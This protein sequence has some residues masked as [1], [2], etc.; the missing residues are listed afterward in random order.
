MKLLRT[1]I[2][3]AL[4]AAPAVARSQ[5]Q[6]VPAQSIPATLAAALYSSSA[7]AS[8]RF[9]VNELPPGYPGSLVPPGHVTILGGT[10]AY[11]EIIALFSDSTQRLAATFEELLPNAGWKTPA[12]RGSGGF[13]SAGAGP[14]NFYCKGDSSLNFVPLTGD[15]RHALRVSLRPTGGGYWCA[16]HQASSGG[17]ATLTLP[18][19][20]APPHATLRSSGG[21]SGSRDVSSYGELTG[22]SL[23]TSAVLEH[24]S[25]QL[26]AAGWTTTPSATSEHASTQYVT[27]KDA[28]GRTWDGA[29]VVFGNSTNLRLMLEMR[30]A[31]TPQ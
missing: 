29:L 10:L 15:F 27:A 6:G 17:H 5:S 30:P 1:L 2:A 24:F 31:S 13:T 19:L 12:P 26:R 4:F 3:S 23:V 21:G 14:S 22:K 25:A 20:S 9:F 11:G 7:S 16:E 28:D 8:T 18:P